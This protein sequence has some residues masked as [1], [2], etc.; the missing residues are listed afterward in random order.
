MPD[1]RRAN[2]PGA[3]YFFTVVTYKRQPLFSDPTCVNLLRTATRRVMQRRPFRIDAMVVLPD[4]I[5][6]IWTLPDGDADFS[7]RWR[8]IKQQ[9]SLNCH[10]PGIA[11]PSPSRTRRRERTFWQRRYWEHLIRDDNDYRR[12]VDYIH[13]NP[14]RH[15]LVAS[16]ADW[17]HGSFRRAVAQGLYPADWGRCEPASIR[18]MALE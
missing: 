13:Y 17:P 14:V 3:S 4:H 11:L 8:M 9:F 6:A 2:S 16:A 10:L 18:G 7:T 15:G 5:H 12:H 1:Y